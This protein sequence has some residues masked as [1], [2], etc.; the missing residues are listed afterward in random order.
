M[1]CPV[2]VKRRISRPGIQASPA[3][4][5]V[6]REARFIRVAPPPGAGPSLSEN[7]LSGHRSLTALR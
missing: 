5:P 6:D 7:S 3:D 1:G 4:H 2:G